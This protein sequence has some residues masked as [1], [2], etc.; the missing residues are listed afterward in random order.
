MCSELWCALNYKSELSWEAVRRCSVSSTNEGKSR[1]CSTRQKQGH[2]WYCGYYR[3]KCD[4]ANSI[5]AFCQESNLSRETALIT[6]DV[7][8]DFMQDFHEDLNREFELLIFSLLL[9]IIIE[10]ANIWI[11]SSTCSCCCLKKTKAS[12]SWVASSI[13]FAICCIAIQS[14]FSS[15][16]LHTWAILFM[17][18]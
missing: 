9:M 11:K 15:W 3:N 5:R 8:M 7:L 14:L 4:F 1:H 12:P 17:K 2:V 13:P 16:Q 18:F 10:I 6:L